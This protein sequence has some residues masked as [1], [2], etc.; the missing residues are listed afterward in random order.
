MFSSNLRGVSFRLEEDNEARPAPKL[1]RSINYKEFSPLDRFGI[2]DANQRLESYKFP[3][4]PNGIS[5]VF[6]H[7]SR[8]APKARLAALT[9]RRSVH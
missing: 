1:N 3:I 5:S 6:C 7:R 2:V 8:P 9:C 4:S